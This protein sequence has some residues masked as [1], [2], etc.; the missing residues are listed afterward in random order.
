MKV[1]VLGDYYFERI[2]PALKRGATKIIVLAKRPIDL[3]NPGPEVEWRIVS[4]AIDRHY[5]L[6]TIG[7]ESIDIVLPRVR[8]T[9]NEGDIVEYARA[10]ELAPRHVKFMAHPLRFAQTVVNK[11]LFHTFAAEHGLLTPNGRVCAGLDAAI[12]AVAALGGFPVV[13]K[14]ACAL[15]MKG[16]HYVDTIEALADLFASKGPGEP[17]LV[18]EMIPGEELGVEIISTPQ[19][20]WRF[21]L[22]SMGRLE[23][24]LNPLARIRTAPKPVPA[25]VE[26]QLEALIQTIEDQLKPFGPWQIDLALSGTKLFILE[27]NPR[28][29]GLSNLDYYCTGINPHALLA[30]I[31]FDQLPAPPK[32][33][34]VA[35]EIPTRSSVGI[36]MP[37]FPGLLGHVQPSR[38]GR[39]WHLSFGTHDFSLAEAMINQIPAD[40]FIYPPAEILEACERLFRETHKDLS[41]G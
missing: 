19:G 41:A 10:A 4:E 32:A 28:L 39:N 1:L 38:T 8:G 34:R 27:I 20:R 33:A 40:A 2:Y 13:V 11:V 30:Q 29:G 22:T 31:A 14:E 26:A 12:E 37:S 24:G 7:E 18:Q 36:S 5:I 23:S 17:L 6:R 25:S 21:P 3:I 15:A 35:I 16:S 9:E